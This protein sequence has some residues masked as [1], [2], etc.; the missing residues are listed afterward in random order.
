MDERTLLG[1]LLPLLHCGTDTVLGPGDDCAAVDTGSPELLL[2]AAD[3]LIAGIHYLRDTTPP[4]LAGAKLFN[5]NASDIAAMGGTPRW[6]LLSL[7]ANGCGNEELLAFAKGAALAAEHCGA[8]LIGGDVAALPTPGLSASLTILGTVKKEEMICRKGANDGDL[9]CVTGCIGNAFHS[10]HHLTFLPRLKEGRFLAEHHLASAMMDISDG[11][12][13]DAARLAEMSCVQILLDPAKV[14]LRKDAVLPEALSDGEDYELLFT[15]PP[16]KLAELAGKMDFT[17]IGEIRSG[18][19]GV[20]DPGG[21]NLLTGKT[22]YEHG[23]Y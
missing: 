13:L 9:L 16:E 4:E 5:R 20:C 2:A 21:N 14:P 10:G 8:T 3:H 11:L 1:Q 18:T 15:V 12:L 6:A 23:K 7:A 19:P 22:G 17:V